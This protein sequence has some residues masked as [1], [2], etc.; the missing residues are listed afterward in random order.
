VLTAQIGSFQLDGGEAV[1]QAVRLIQS[2][3]GGLLSAHPGTDLLTA[4]R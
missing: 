3:R 2:A 1:R 4:R